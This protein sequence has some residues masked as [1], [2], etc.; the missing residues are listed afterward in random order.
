LRFH[1]YHLLNCI[2]IICDINEII[3]FW[4]LDLL[5][6]AAN[7][8][9]RNSQQLKLLPTYLHPLQDPVNDP[10]RHEQSLFCQSELE[11]HLDQPV[12][13]DGPHLLG[14]VGLAHGNRAEVVR[15]QPVEDRAVVVR[16]FL[17]VRRE[18]RN[19]R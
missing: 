3:D 13:E 19:R 2:S 18:D 10:H 12:D 17:W 11:V 16:G 15:K 1:I 8:Q 6:L 14:E 9:C 4:H 5:D 7:K